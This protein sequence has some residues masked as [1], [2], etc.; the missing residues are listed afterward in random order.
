MELE[1]PPTVAQY[2]TAE[3]LTVDE[4]STLADAVDRMR[5]N[6]IHHLIVRRHRRMVGLLSRTDL[7]LEAALARGEAGPASLE[8]AMRPAFTCPPHAPLAWVALEMESH[9][10]E[11]VVVVDHDDSVVLG[12]FTLGDALRALRRLALGHGA[13]VASLPSHAPQVFATSSSLPSGAHARTHYTAPSA[14]DGN[15]YGKLLA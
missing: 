9:R 2:M 13:P 4:G 3:P 10:L 5:A 1:H 15:A 6:N 11:A 14:N 7:E 12:I 8:A